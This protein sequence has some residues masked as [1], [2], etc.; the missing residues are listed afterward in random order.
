MNDVNNIYM[1]RK[2]KKSEQSTE[3]AL[4]IQNTND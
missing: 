1:E 4:N 2:Q 3:D